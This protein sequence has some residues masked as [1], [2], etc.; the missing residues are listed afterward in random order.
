MGHIYEKIGKAL[1]ERLVRAIVFSLPSYALANV[2]E[3]LYGLVQFDKEVIF[4]LYTRCKLLILVKLE[5][6]YINFSFFR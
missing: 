4:T 3:V 5:F 1:V 6:Q 2:A